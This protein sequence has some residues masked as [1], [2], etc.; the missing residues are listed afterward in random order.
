MLPLVFPSRYSVL[1]YTP[2]YGGPGTLLVI[3]SIDMLIPSKER[4]LLGG[5]QAAR[6]ARAAVKWARNHVDKDWI[7]WIG[8]GKIKVPLIASSA[9]K[10]F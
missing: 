10:Q 4:G 7:E 5:P 3:P 2:E 1:S 9:N 6:A 8:S